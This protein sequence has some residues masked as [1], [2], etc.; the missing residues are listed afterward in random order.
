M[1]FYCNYHYYII[2][3]ATYY[4][5]HGPMCPW[6]VRL[7]ATGRPRKPGAATSQKAPGWGQKARWSKFSQFSC[8]IWYGHFLW[9]NPMP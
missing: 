1:L 7:V 2:I 4:H 3:V 8:E 6:E 9:G 5:Y